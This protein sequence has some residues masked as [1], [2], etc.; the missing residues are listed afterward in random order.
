MNPFSKK[1]AEYI[2]Q[3]PLVVKLKLNGNALSFRTDL[4]PG[5]KWKTET[6]STRQ[7]EEQITTAKHIPYVI[8]VAILWVVH[9]V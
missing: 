5:G 4:T 2:K 8:L 7:D 9:G 3:D 6:D 1:K